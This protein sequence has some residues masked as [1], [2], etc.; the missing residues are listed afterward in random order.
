M[1][2]HTHETC[3]VT[4]IATSKAACLCNFPDAG[5]KEIWVPYSLIENAEAVDKNAQ[6]CELGIVK[7]FLNKNEL[8]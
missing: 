4:V 7:W 3:K 1:G 6:F 5:D 8:K 2:V